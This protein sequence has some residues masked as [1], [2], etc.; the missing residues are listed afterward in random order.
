MIGWGD[1]LPQI[2]QMPQRKTAF[3]CEFSEICGPS[4]YSLNKLG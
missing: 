1:N 2:A 3:F 4:S